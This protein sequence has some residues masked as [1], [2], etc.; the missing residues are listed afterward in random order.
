MD[1]ENFFLDVTRLCAAGSLQDVSKGCFTDHLTTAELKAVVEI[2]IGMHFIEVFGHFLFR[3]QTQ[4][5]M[6]KHVSLNEDDLA[7][8]KK[9]KMDD[10]PI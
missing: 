1:R 10:Y 7:M 4:Y 3:V 2:A 5:I 8:K 6:D 9:K